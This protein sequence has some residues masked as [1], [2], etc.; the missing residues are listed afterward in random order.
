MIF[1]TNSKDVE[2]EEDPQFLKWNFDSRDKPFN[3]T[4][5]WILE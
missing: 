1:F 5:D 3:V 4:N 2:I